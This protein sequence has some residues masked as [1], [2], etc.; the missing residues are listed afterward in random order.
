MYLESRGMVDARTAF[1]GTSI[2]AYFAAGYP[3]FPD[4]AARAPILAA[5]YECVAAR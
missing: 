1:L 5:S 2:D 4:V 3:L